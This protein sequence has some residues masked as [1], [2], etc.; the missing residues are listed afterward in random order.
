MFRSYVRVTAIGLRAAFGRSCHRF[1]VLI[2]LIVCISFVSGFVTMSEGHLSEG[3]ST[4][5]SV[6]YSCN[7]FSVIY[8]TCSLS[9]GV[10]RCMSGF[11]L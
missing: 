10:L 5:T 9:R 6:Q 3:K 11:V 2:V 1:C 7:K 8:T 4:V